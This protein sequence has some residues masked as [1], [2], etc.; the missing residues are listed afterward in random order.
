[1]LLYLFSVTAGTMILS[2]KYIYTSDV[3]H[4]TRVFTLQHIAWPQSR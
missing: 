3:N 4:T 2:K 1:M